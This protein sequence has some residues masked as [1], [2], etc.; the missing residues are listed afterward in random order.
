MW[1]QIVVLMCFYVLA[2]AGCGIVAESVISNALGS[3][4]G[5][6]AA[7]EVRDARRDK[8]SLVTDKAEGGYNGK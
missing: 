2:G 5:T 8:Q 4:V 3:F 6:Y 1:L 7:G